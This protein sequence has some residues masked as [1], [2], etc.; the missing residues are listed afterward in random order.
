MRV[1]QIG[2]AVVAMSTAVSAGAA[3]CSIP[4]EAKQVD[5]VEYGFCEADAVFIGKVEERLETIRAYRAEGS[6][7][8]QHFRIEKS[9]LVPSKT[10]K[11]DLAKKL[12]F[13]ADLYDKK[14][15]TFSFERGKEYLVFAKRLADGEYTGAS[16]ACS[17]QPTVLVETA[18]TARQRLEDHRSGKSKIDCKKL[19]PKS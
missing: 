3:E 13:T 15:G 19:A 16:A 1:L 17:V 5:P 14:T 18:D 4:E 2:F 7:R 12:T 8:T 9:T 11:G 6:D 10:F